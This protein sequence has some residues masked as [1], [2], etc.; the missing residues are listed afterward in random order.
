MIN[1]TARK[2]LT[3]VSYRGPFQSPPAPVDFPPV[4][5]STLSAAESG[6][7]LGITVQTAVTK[8]ET[9]DTAPD[10]GDGVPVSATYGGIIREDHN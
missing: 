3:Q 6:A 10:A 7:L 9:I 4:D 8:T 2:A 1:R 5:P